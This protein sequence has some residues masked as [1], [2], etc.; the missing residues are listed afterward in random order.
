ML[1]NKITIRSQL[2]IVI[3]K[4]KVISRYCANPP[5]D[6]AS[7]ERIKTSAPLYPRQEVIDLACKQELFLWSDGARVDAA[8]WGFDTESLC[9]LLKTHLATARYRNSSWCEAKPNGPWAACD[10]YVITTYVWCDIQG[11]TVRKDDYIKLAISVAGK[12]ALV[13]NH[14][15]GA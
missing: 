10:A 2:I 1:R 11:K 8:K 5:A 13:S 3:N 7:G 4:R 6:E 12:I 14:P 9:D 15:E